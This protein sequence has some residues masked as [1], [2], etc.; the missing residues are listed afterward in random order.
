MMPEMEMVKDAAL[1]YDKPTLGRMAQMGQL[2][3]TIA[4]M[5][6]MMRDR[7]VQSEMKPPAP[8]TVAEEVMQPMGQ[9]MGLG[10]IAPGAE[11]QGQPQ[12]PPQGGLSQI[13]V[14]EQMFDRP[15]MA[16]GGIVAFQGGG[17]TFSSALAGEMSVD[18]RY[19]RG[20][21]A[22]RGARMPRKELVDLMTLAE[23]QEFNRSGAI[24]ER[25][26]GQVQGRAIEGVRQF[27]GDMYDSQPSA[28]APAMVPSQD[29]AAETAKLTRQAQGTG[30]PGGIPSA[31]PEPAPTPKRQPIVQTQP[32]TQEAAS[33]GFGSIL[34]QI[35]GV[36][37][38]SKA[39]EGLESEVLKDREARAEDKK[40]A[41]WLRLAEAGLGIMGGESPYFAVNVG[42]GAAGAL[43]GYAEDLREQKKLDREDRKILADIE[44]AR[45]AEAAGNIKLAADLNSRALDR[46]SQEQQ[47]NIRVEATLKA[48]MMQASKPSA[49]V[50]IIERMMQDP[51]FKEAAIDFARA[52]AEAKDPEKAAMAA[53]I[54][55]AIA[56]GK[57]VDISN[58]IKQ[59]PIQPTR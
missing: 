58:L 44:Q 6:G 22:A 23:L 28:A 18:P 59:Y 1:K 55:Q 49:Q 46:M 45:R 38:Q 17:G 26:A 20:L 43:K 3:P 2:S 10:A 35:Q 56:G 51:K 40:Q 11:M 41:G 13:P 48:A 31:L 7:I 12:Q 34:S 29:L 53:L 14:P 33:T 37:P 39:Y 19:L 9:R 27:G 5:A 15:E 30:V 54:N 57:P 32:A 16:N 25:L 52:Q 4:V 42:K 21:Q 50:E 8:P 36:M 47:N 24:P